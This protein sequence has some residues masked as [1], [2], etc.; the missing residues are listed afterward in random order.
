MKGCFHCSSGQLCKRCS[1]ACSLSSLPSSPKLGESKERGTGA[2]AAE[3]SY[4]LFLLSDITD[5]WNHWGERLEPSPTPPITWKQ[6]NHRALLWASVCLSSPL[7]WWGR[8]HLTPSWSF[9]GQRFS[10]SSQNAILPYF[11]IKK[12]VHFLLIN[13]HL[14]ALRPAISSPPNSI[15][16][17][18]NS[19]YPSHP[20][21]W[22]QRAL[23][24]LQAVAE[25]TRATM[26]SDS[27]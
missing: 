6:E 20:T 9:F 17:R 4:P 1:A 8:G 22:T 3:P 25:M 18:P 21:S 13:S 15:L 27:P 16:S 23:A 11:H 7:R 19:L 10:S 24:A 2:S 14:V 5:S 26:T 12:S